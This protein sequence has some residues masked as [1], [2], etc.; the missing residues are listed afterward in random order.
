M[1][2]VFQ[3]LGVFPPGGRQVRQAVQIGRFRNGGRRESF[4]RVQS[5]LIFW[6]EARSTLLERAAV[7]QARRSI[8]IFWLEAKSTF[9]GREEFL[10]AGAA[11]AMRD[12]VGGVWLPEEPAQA[13]GLL[14]PGAGGAGARAPEEAI[15]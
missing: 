8:W 4:Q 14:A 2:L 15:L 6:L 5:S 10:L 1:V 13:D 12:V 3:E 11:E 9:A 7:L